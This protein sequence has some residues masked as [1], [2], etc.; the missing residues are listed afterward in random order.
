MFLGYFID[1]HILIDESGNDYRFTGDYQNPDK[2]FNIVK[3]SPE[4]YRAEQY[5][6]EFEGKGT[7]SEP[8]SYVLT[9]KNQTKYYFSL[10]QLTSMREY[11]ITSYFNP[12]W[13][14]NTLIPVYLLDAKIDRNGNGILYHRDGYGRIIS[15]GHATDWTSGSVPIQVPNGT[16]YDRVS[17]NFEI[18]FETKYTKTYDGSF[19]KKINVSYWDSGPIRSVEC[20]GIKYD[21]YPKT[22][23]VRMRPSIIKPFYDLQAIIQR[24]SDGNFKE[25]FNYFHRLRYNTK[26]AALNSYTTFMTERS[27]PNGEITSYDYKL[28]NPAYVYPYTWNRVWS[29]FRDSIY[30]LSQINHQDGTKTTFHRHI[31]KNYD[32]GA[33]ATEVVKAN[34]D[35]DLYIFYFKYDAYDPYRGGNQL[36]DSNSELVFEKRIFINKIELDRLMPMQINFPSFNENTGITTPYD[37]DSVSVLYG[38][39][40]RY[41]PDFLRDYNGNETTWLYKDGWGVPHEVTDGEGNKYEYEYDSTYHKRIKE[42]DPLGRETRY[43]LDFDGNITRKSE[44]NGSSVLRTI[45]AAY[46]QQGNLT[47]HTDGNGHITLY[48]YDSNGDLIKKTDPPAS[49]GSMSGDTT[50]AYNYFG[51]K[52]EVIDPN[53]NVSTFDY[54]GKLRLVRENFPVADS[55]LEEFREYT[56]DSKDNRITSLDENGNITHFTYNEANRLTEREDPQVGKTSYQYDGIGNLTRMVD[57]NN[58]E[59]TF[60]YD[61]LSRLI[62]QR[63]H[64]GQATTFEY[65]QNFGSD[66]FDGQEFKPN[67]ITDAKGNVKEF[68]YDKLYRTLFEVNANERS[69]G[70]EYD[71]LGNLVLQKDWWGNETRFEYDA[72]NRQVKQISPAPFYYETHSVHDLN[73]NVIQVEDANTNLTKSTYDALNRLVAVEDSMT[74]ITQYTYDAVGNTATVKRADGHTTS[75]DYDPR[76]RLVAV[77]EALAS[78]TFNMAY[79]YDGVGNRT[80]Q[81]DS[82]GNTIDFTY[83]SNNWLTLENWINSGKSFSYTYDTAGRRL[84]LSDDTGVTNYGYDSLNRLIRVDHPNNRALEYDYDSV[85]NRSQL[86]YYESSSLT[87]QIS[88]TYNKL[89]QIE[90]LTDFENN[91]T[92]FEYDGLERRSKTNYSNG[93]TMENTYDDLSRIIGKKYSDTSGTIDELEYTYDPVGNILNI[94]DTVR[95]E[96]RTFGY[97]NLYRLTN[98]NYPA[99]SVDY[100]Y[101][102]IGNRLTENKSDGTAWNFTYN[103]RGQ[104]DEKTLSAYQGTPVSNAYTAYS[105]DN[106]GNQSS[107]IDNFQID[108]VAG[109]VIPTSAFTTS[110]NWDQRDQLA[111]VQLPDLSLYEYLYNGDGVR[112]AKNTP[113]GTEQYVYD[114]MNILRELDEN[115]A[116]KVSYVQ[117]LTLDQLISKSDG[118]STAYYHGDILGSVRKMTDIAGNVVK[119]YEYDAWGNVLEDTG[120]EDNTYGFTGRRDETKETGLMYYR[121]RYYDP[122]VGR[123]ISRDPYSGGPDDARVGYRN[124]LYSALHGE[125]TLYYSFRQPHRFNRYAYVHNNPLGFTDPLGLYDVWASWEREGTGKT[126]GYS[127]MDAIKAV[128]DPKTQWKLIEKSKVI[129]KKTLQAAEIAKEA[130]KSIAEVYSKVEPKIPGLEDKTESIED[131]LPMLGKMKR[132]EKP[133]KE[134]GKDFVEESAKIIGGGTIVNKVKDIVEDKKD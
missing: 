97:D 60:S 62:S 64:M 18:V 106:N 53:G 108:E 113:T 127:T 70:F 17:G 61:G 44:F 8:Y 46:D 43:I 105:Y 129:G 34:G 41:N 118:A 90:T 79:E 126:K 42:I 13:D 115:G 130:T 107:K 56:Y 71:T 16:Q 89:N 120:I 67:R 22:N 54:D 75:F 98:A 84:S 4:W 21:F 7:Q 35:R 104:L 88:Y 38:Y 65:F 102:A 28:V 52:T 69:I 124:T 86:R 31:G 49:S 112:M 99:Y 95:L 51:Q 92:T 9:T 82:N 132:S 96:T 91:I 48:E 93:V 33:K 14:E 125:L 40:E 85:G 76:N 110:Y 123:F 57:P 63:D 109:T 128:I 121:A 81:V 78:G 24:T 55:E 131:F 1:L 39:D 10:H 133:I 116:L 2:V 80:K 3:K 72:L 23:Q 27:L 87:D 37:F 74:G 30:R 26:F 12:Y 73:D 134:I 20:G 66:I 25:E 59:T 100:T 101:D 111:S 11:Y 94:N 19:L 50:I 68:V 122:M 32:R 5:S 119:S 58:L 117:E 45:D 15:Y 36:Y 47:Q 114:G 29:S 103:D 83:N 6:L 77:E